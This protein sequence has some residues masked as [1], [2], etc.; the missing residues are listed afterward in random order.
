VLVSPSPVDNFVLLDERDDSINDGFF[1]T[2]MTGFNPPSPGALQIIDFPSSYHNGAC[3]FNFGD[4]HAQFKRWLDPR[5]KANHVTDYHLTLGPASPN[6]QD[7][8]WLQQHATGK[9]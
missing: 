8:A 1:I 5:T 2:E 3:G 4:G 9:K 6:N 7:I